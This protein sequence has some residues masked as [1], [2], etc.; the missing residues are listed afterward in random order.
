[1]KERNSVIII[2]S[3]SSNYKNDTNNIKV[4]NKKRYILGGVAKKKSRHDMC[5]LPMLPQMPIY[6]SE[7]IRTTSKY[8]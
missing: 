6:Y 5:V 3:F 7:S 1:M 8:L 2:P 4:I